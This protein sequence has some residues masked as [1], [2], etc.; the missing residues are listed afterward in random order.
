MTPEK[1]RHV[2]RLLGLTQAA[3]AE[4]LQVDVRTV[5]RWVSGERKVPGPAI[6][7][8]ECW[9]RKKHEH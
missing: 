1:F 2:M 3:T 6:A 4:L 8:L 9:V 7:A 5:R